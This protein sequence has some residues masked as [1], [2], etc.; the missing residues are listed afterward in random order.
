MVRWQHKST[1]G[2][3]KTSWD[4]GSVIWKLLESH[5]FLL[6]DL[7]T[8]W[9]DPTLYELQ[10]C[11]T[12]TYTWRI[13][14]VWQWG[15]NSRGGFLANRGDCMGHCHRKLPRHRD[16]WQPYLSLN[17]PRAHCSFHTEDSL[18][19]FAAPSK[20]FVA[21]FHMNGL[22]LAQA[23]NFAKTSKTCPTP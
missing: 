11:G 15:R 7:H 17:Q 10:C 12:Q 4:C 9:Q 20:L 14:I 13:W 16:D 1:S 21:A 5:M 22:S 23:S 2:Y 8:K 19:H 3:S 18:I 6:K